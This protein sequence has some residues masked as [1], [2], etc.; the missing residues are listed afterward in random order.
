MVTITT[1][2][3]SDGKRIPSLDGL[4]GVAILLVLVHN[5]GTFQVRASSPLLK[6]IYFMHAPGWIGV[7]LFFVLS[8]FL[9]TGILLDSQ[10]P[11]A[12]RLF[13]I[14]RALRIFPLYFTFLLLATL[15]APWLSR[16]AEFQTHREA[17]WYWTYMC[18]WGQPEGHRIPAFAHFWSLAV[19]E[20]FYLVWP[21]L[22]LL[23]ERRVLFRVS[24]ALAV[25]AAILRI[26]LSRLGMSEAIYSYTITR[27][28]A[29]TLGAAAAVIA[30]DSAWLKHV[31]PHLKGMIIWS[32]A[33]LVIMWPFTHGFHIYD[34]RVQILGYGVLSLLFSSL[35]L[36][37]FVDSGGILSRVLCVPWLRWFGKYSYAIYVFHLP[38]AVVIAH[39]LGPIINGPA[40]GPA[41]V[42]LFTHVSLVAIFSICGALLSWNLLEKRALALKGHFKPHTA[43]GSILLQQKR[44]A[45]EDVL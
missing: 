2:V 13:W 23:L 26:V 7:Q 37:T 4:R 39:K 27:M 42:A 21:L 28:D 43:T 33:L 38:I 15:A 3:T 41:L 24:I 30:R 8:G 19:E 6:V 1:Q 14:R 29:L 11:G 10:G 44:P 22:A 9:I 34:A 17:W 25:V 31:V 16:L 18:N 5:A 32:A 45:T 40:T 20:Q 36:R 12:L 35:V